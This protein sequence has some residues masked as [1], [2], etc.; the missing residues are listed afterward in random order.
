MELT[1]FFNKKR[2]TTIDKT[3]HYTPPFHREVLA[4]SI[5]YIPALGIAGILAVYSAYSLARDTTEE[6]TERINV[7]LPRTL[8]AAHNLLELTAPYIPVFLR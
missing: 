3:D 6:I 4:N 2:K 8:S 5:D 7:K 1:I